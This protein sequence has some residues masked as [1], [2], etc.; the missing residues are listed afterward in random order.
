MANLSSKLDAVTVYREGALCR[1]RAVVPAGSDRQVRLGQLPLSLDAGTFRARVVS[2]SP[3]VLDV[4][5]QFDVEFAAEADVPAEQLALEAATTRVA[6]LDQQR[7]RVQAEIVELQALKPSTLEARRGD[8]PRPSNMEAM[9][10]LGEF[11]DE[12]LRP[13]LERRRAL[14]RELKDA[15]EEAT[16]RQRRLAEV[17]SAR[18]TERSK[19]WRVAVIMLSEAP[20][21][22]AEIEL[23]YRVPGARW[24]P[25]YT[26]S[27]ERGMTGG[28]LQMRAS[29]AQDTGEDWSQVKLGLSTAAWSRRA[30]VPELKALKVGRTQPEPARSGWR[31][32][33]PGLDA[34]FE[35]YDAALGPEDLSPKGGAVATGSLQKVMSEMPKPM[36][37]QAP[38]PPPPAPMAPPSME[39]LAAPPMQ[40]MR[41]SVAAPGA[42]PSAS[43]PAPQDLAR[44]RS[45]PRGGAAPMA[46]KSSGLGGMMREEAVEEMAPEADE[47]MDSE[48]GG[49]GFGFADEPAMLPSAPGLDAQF[50]DYARLRMP[51]HERGPGRGRLTSASEWDF[52]FV[53]GLSVQIDVVMA[54]VVR[55]QNNANQVAHLTLPSLCNPVSSI[56]SFDYAYDCAAR[57]DVPSTGKW[58]LVPVMTC[59][60]ALTPEYVCVPSVESKVYRTLT[61]S[62]LSLHALLPGPVD[63]TSGEEF[64]LT[65][66]LPAIPPG[67]DHSHRLGLGVEESIKVARKTQFKE[68][69][70]GFLGGS[71]VLPHEIEIELN[72]RLASPA[73]IEVRERLPVV[74]PTEKDLKVEEAQ[75]TPG[76]EKVEGPVDGEI[77]NGARRWRVTVPPGQQ[78]KLTAQ[79]TIRMPADRMLVGGN[80]RN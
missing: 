47:F 51:R 63:V 76:W 14:D 39:M 12:A 37:R 27:L 49:G 41:R 46:K 52:A 2:G 73:L 79:F 29:V 22:G 68:T 20:A 38:P 30:D 8:P 57:L 21:E 10:A 31:E 18:R 56:K 36:P 25:S 66:S 42:M 65:T 26:L 78:M 62:N 74:D 54:V 9:L 72:N 45:M 24:V 34:L 17:T 13:R 64:L 60:V 3:R 15:R 1:R 6:Q 58:V 7:A 5:A 67:A 71:T 19:L 61:I 69:T 40:A 53:A 77:I 43:M 80:R 35:A 33:P 23:E 70:G 55:A 28:T 48:G 75:T 32:P 16:L 4:R 59:P 50:G 11:T 44:A